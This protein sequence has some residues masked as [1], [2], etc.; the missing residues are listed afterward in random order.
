MLQLRILGP[1]DL[2]APDGSSVESVLAQPKRMALLSY[3]VLEG[4]GGTVRRDLLLAAFWPEADAERGRASLRRSL[5]F[6]RKALG[7]GL[8]VARG[9]AVGVAPGSLQCDATRLLAELGAGRLEAAVELYRGELLAGIHLR[10]NGEFEDWMAR[11]R[12]RLRSLVGSALWTL[13]DR[14][15][16]GGD[17]RA[18]AHWS[19]RAVA[20]TPYDEGVQRRR[21]ALLLEG[22]DHAGALRAYEEF[23]GWLAREYQGTP[24]AETRSLVAALR[25]DQPIAAPRPPAAPHEAP[26][27]EPAAAGEWEANPGEAD[28]AASPVAGGRPAPSRPAAA[29]GLTPPTP[30]SPATPASTPVT[31]STPGPARPA[32]RRARWGVVGAILAAGAVAAGAAGS[33]LRQEATTDEQVRTMPARRGDDLGVAVLPFAVRGEARLGYLGEGLVDLLSTQL[34]GVGPLR[35][36]DPHALLGRLAS[37][38]AGDDDPLAIG[39][40][41]A[42]AF[43][44]DLFVTGSVVQAGGGR[45]ELRASLYQRDGALV[46]T[47]AARGSEMELTAAVDGLAR[48]LLA[49]RYDEP[50]QQLARLAVRTTGSMPAL[51]A[52]LAGN[53]LL[54][55][56]RFAQAADSQRAALAADTGFALAYHGLSMALGW[57]SYGGDREATIAA[58]EAVKR[59]ARLGPRVSATLR[60]HHASWNGRPEEADRL[61][62]EI[63]GSYPDDADARNGLAELIFHEGAWRG[64]TP[65]D[66]AAAFRRVA[67]VPALRPGALLHLARIAASEGDAARLESIA[68]ELSVELRD[69]TGDRRMQEV[70]AL[71]AFV[72]GGA[73]ARRAVLARAA[74]EAD[75]RRWQLAWSVARFTGAWH[76]AE[77]LVLGLTTPDRPATTRAPAWLGVAMLRAAAGQPVG[78]RAA[79]DSAAKDDQEWAAIARA[80]LDALPF[81]PA[82]DDELAHARAA[83]HS[84]TGSPRPAHGALPT[85][86]TLATQAIAGGRAMGALNRRASLAAEWPYYLNPAGMVGPDRRDISPAGPRRP[87]ASLAALERDWAD[88]TAGRAHFLSMN[89]YQRLR[90][91]YLLAASGRPDEADR[92]YATIPTPDGYEVALVAPATLA[93]A[94]LAESEGRMDDAARLYERFARLWADCEPELRPLVE[95][96]R[97]RAESILSGSTGTSRNGVP[98]LQGA[99]PAIP[100]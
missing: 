30:P 67:E 4:R 38:E 49:G 11:E 25:T 20:L 61:Y 39:R 45:L 18:S 40:A 73:P 96:A 58:E 23:A 85:Y 51:R 19:A 9:D 99:S 37:M 17:A 2:T 93:R 5:H 10:G 74:G 6:L 72:A 3:L 12:E 80:E 100:Q 89:A 95:E 50:G 87:A 57:Y 21:I 62:R 33:V 71:R 31:P 15:M 83:L 90:R 55:N 54:R 47:A 70:E 81:L 13:A 27:P 65:E 29:G 35:T 79:L 43:D 91:G 88:E 59:S 52:Y 75:A 68:R 82:S 34:D 7:P 94:R 16:E 69:T 92:W 32:R 53:Q 76:A 63:L 14:A 41:A 86:F 64:Q 48:E 77:S 44:A 26:E 1:L 60:A 36:V 98:N 42:R 28:P 46:T 78:A 22:G 8:I 24:S 84:A 56:G 66:A 97:R